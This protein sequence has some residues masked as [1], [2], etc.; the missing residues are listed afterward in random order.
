VHGIEE[1]MNPDDVVILIDPFEAEVEKI[2]DVLVKGVGMRVFAVAARDTIFPTIRVNELGELS[3]YAYLAAG[4]NIL[5]EVGVASNINLDK[6]VR[7]RKVG[8][9]FVG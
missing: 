7:A 1:V 9:E 6:P 4:W 3:T 8:N 5:V 2:R